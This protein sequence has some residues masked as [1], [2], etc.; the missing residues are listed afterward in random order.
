MFRLV[1]AVAAA[2]WFISRVMRSSRRIQLEGKVVV[3]TGARGLGFEMAQLVS[4]LGAKVCLLARDSNELER[5]C[6][7]LRGEA[8]GI[9]CDVRDAASCE[10][11]IE[12][13]IAH[14]GGVDALINNAGIMQDG[15]MEHMKTKD[16]EDAL[17]THFWG[18]L[19]MIN[20]VLPHMR[21][22][23]AG[24]IVN[25]ASVGGLV[26]IPHMAPYVASKHALVGLSD[27]LRAELS[28]DGICVTTVSPGLI[29]TGSY[30]H[31]EFKGQQEDEAAIFS[32]VSASRLTAMNPEWAALRIIDAMR[33]GDPALVLS[34]SAKLAAI[35]DAV[36]PGLT[37]EI[38]AL[39]AKA[40]PGPT[41]AKEGDAAKKG[42]DVLHVAAG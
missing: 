2:P 14:F 1:A 33:Y 13:C 27:A 34:W 38:M 25:I 19:H 5:A 42:K 18:P 35:A 29:A 7:R 9:H 23:K 31:A 10:K 12:S 26:G 40:L 6:D 20:A 16:Y 30:L 3:I 11:A 24:R 37:A 8:I 22:R 36:A 4:R 32:F 21:A 17:A 39:V 41:V 28:K 15:P